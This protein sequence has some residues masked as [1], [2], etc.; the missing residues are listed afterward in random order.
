MY[1]VTYQDGLIGLGSGKDQSIPST[2]MVG[3]KEGMD[4]QSTDQGS[5]HIIL[6]SK[7]Y[8]TITLDLGQEVEKIRDWDDI[9]LVIIFRQGCDQRFDILQKERLTDIKRPTSNRHLEVS[10]SFR[11]TCKERSFER[12]CGCRDSLFESRNGAVV[13]DGWLF[14]VVIVWGLEPVVVLIWVVIREAGSDKVE[15]VGYGII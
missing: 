13:V 7:L 3:H 12:V 2:A 14:M 5:F 4:H 9:G 15:G 10:F 11:K 6:L 8:E 1:R